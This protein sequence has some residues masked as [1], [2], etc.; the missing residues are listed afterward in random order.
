MKR[1]SLHVVALCYGCLVAPPAQA[2][3]PVEKIDVQNSRVYV[4]VAKKGAGHDHGVEGRLAAGTVRLGQAAG[5]GDMTF[6]LKA[7]Q[8]D[9]D[10][11][12][13]FIGLPGETDA[14][15]QAAATT[16]MRSA[17]VLDVAQFAAAKYTIDAAKP[18]AAVAGLPGASYQ[19]DGEL[20]LHGVKKK[21][22]F[23]GGVEALDGG[24]IRIRGRFPLKQ[25]DFGIKPF[26]KLLGAVGIADELQVYGDIIL[27]P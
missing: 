22:S 27:V 18:V 15:D 14:S 7:F 12:R 23:Y 3:A 6:D 10:V 20:E 19:F 11:A 8:V 13:R 2:Q 21:I 9:S 1:S 26:S 5:A 4:F 17:A 24:R 16:N 25:T